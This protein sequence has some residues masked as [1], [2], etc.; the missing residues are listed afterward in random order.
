MERINL[1][2]GRRRWEGFIEDTREWPKQ[3]EREERW[4][5]LSQNDPAKENQNEATAL[6]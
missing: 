2:V 4:R 1:A 3:K 6:S 5:A